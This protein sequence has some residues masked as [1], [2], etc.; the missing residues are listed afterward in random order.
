MKLLTTEIDTGET[1][2][3]RL[4]R[5]A[6]KWHGVGKHAITFRWAN[7][8]L[9]SAKPR[10]RKE[11]VEWTSQMDHVLG[12]DADS[13]IARQFGVPTNS[14]CKRREKLRIPPFH[15]R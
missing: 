15:E 9:V 11:R 1:E 2:S 3:N 14:V 10:E 4:F 6:I 12:T 8:V 5:S 7:D 13:V